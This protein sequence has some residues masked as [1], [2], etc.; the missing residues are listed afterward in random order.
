M[1][2]AQREMFQGR[3]GLMGLRHYYKHFVKNNTK[4]GSA[5]KNVEV[6]SSRYL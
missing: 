6:F 1:R 3:G 2:G 5:G 4:K